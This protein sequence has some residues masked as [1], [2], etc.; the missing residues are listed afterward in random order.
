M[1]RPA[2]ARFSV[3]L[4]ACAGAMW[5]ASCEGDVQR[6]APP[7]N[8]PESTGTFTGDTVDTVGSGAGGTF[9]T[10]GLGGWGGDFGVGGGVDEDGA[11]GGGRTERDAQVDGCAVGP[12]TAF[13]LSDLN[14]IGTP[15]NGFGPVE[16]DTSN[17][18][19]AAGDGHPM[20]ISGTPFAKG[21][22]VNANSSIEFGLGA[23]C[24]TFSA[25]VG[26]DDEVSSAS[27]TFEVWVDGQ[28]SYS[29]PSLVRSGQ[30]PAFVTVDVSCASSLRLVVTDGVVDGNARDHA[31]WGDAKVTCVSRPGT[32]YVDAAVDRSTADARDARD[33]SVD[34]SVTPEP[35][36]SVDAPA[37]RP[38][39]ALFEFSRPR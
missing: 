6:A 20:S 33:A 13:Y 34:S 3:V 22:G 27:I 9:D 11:A 25:Y 1:L 31:D 15:V 26:A 38:Q 10:T 18:E 35:D 24:R 12:V 36:A 39:D 17:G 14:W 16:R 32:S 7:A 8:R 29:S 19:M 30:A 28:R 4:L 21:L 37:D 23:K 5:L 2:G